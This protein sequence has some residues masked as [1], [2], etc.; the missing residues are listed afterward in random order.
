MRQGQ[1][2]KTKKKIFFSPVQLPFKVPSVI[3]THIFLYR[4][5]DMMINIMDATSPMNAAMKENTSWTT[6]GMNPS[7]FQVKQ[8]GMQ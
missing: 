8:L 5:N 2:K 3:C 6:D 1:Q 7:C 4:R